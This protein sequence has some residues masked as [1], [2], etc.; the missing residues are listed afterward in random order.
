MTKPTDVAAASLAAEPASTNGTPRSIPLERR[1]PLLIL[2]LLAFVLA[3]S[4][5]VSY[6]EISAS[7]ESSGRDRL[8]S[9][10]QV[11]GSMIQQQ[12]AARLTTMHHAAADSAVVNAL[13]SPTRP[14]SAAATAALSALMTRAD[15]L[16]PARLLTA[17]GDPIGE[18]HLETPADEERF[19]T[20]I[21]S[22]AESVDSSHVGNWYTANGHASFWIAVPVRQNGRVLG[23]V[24]QERRLTNNPRA[25][26]PFRD[27]IGKDIELY[28]RNAS[29]NV[30][31][32]L[33]GASPAP[34]AER[35]SDSI[36]VFA[37]GAKGQVLAATAPVRGTPFL[38]TVEYPMRQL[39][40]RPQATIRTLMVIAVLLTVF[41]A[42][43]AWLI[44]RQLTRPLVELTGAAEAMAE[45]Q[46]A[47]RVRAHGSDEI[48]R[49]GVAFNRMAEQVQVS[50]NASDEAVV[51]LTYSAATQEF[52]AE[53]SRILAESLSDQTLLADLARY[54]VPTLADYSSI[55]VVDDDGSVRRVETAHYDATK[56]D[57][58]RDLVMRYAPRLEEPG[59]VSDVIRSQKPMLLPR[60]DP[61]SIR[62][63]AP[64]ETTAKLIDIIGPTAF[65]CVPLIA[66]GRALGAL[67]FTMTDSGRTFSQDDLDLA[68]ELA[69]RTA[70][71]IDNSV[72]YK[73]SLQLR[74]EAEAASSAKSDFLAKMSHEIRT[75]INAMMG[76][77][78]LLE[79]GISGPVSDAQARQL[80]RIR[81]SGEHLT[82]L[83][84]E[85]LDLAKI[86]AGR[87]AVDPTVGVSG[88]AVDAALGLIRPQAAAK[89]VHLVNKTATGPA[90]EYLGDPQR[91]QQILTNLLSNAVKFTPAGG[92]VIIRA[93]TG[94]R[95]GVADPRAEWTCIVV[96]DT[97]I[98]IG[99]ADLERIFQPFVQV[100]NGY[101]RAHGGTGLGLT[102]SRSLAQMM[103]GG[104][105]VESTVGEG[106]RF[107]LW[108]PSPVA[109][110]L[111]TP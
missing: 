80:S 62:A 108:L 54:C 69:R 15:S 96:Q 47:Q 35:I 8:T 18:M 60:L 52:L 11:I 50:S 63:K 21:R 103:G 78:E 28:F 16:T 53:A 10:S 41:G 14:P 97:G 29:D 39:L 109:V 77:A 37:H 17:N 36:A 13:R 75:P 25:L 6:Y 91:V 30:W 64:D 20:E 32:D 71:A 100:E 33:T 12:V 7:A 92:T 38:I 104:L 68:M 4:L 26:Q 73:R 86:E 1:L 84:N 102:I 74:L 45:G 79:M 90:I 3:I 83:V 82:S 24:A 94:Q 48:G 56:R 34:P 44:S 67:S 111:P 76:Y 95:P 49:L 65:M 88:E 42:L 101:T 81:S 40:A 51:R 46:Y 2:G 99:A 61:A 70:V 22:L 5:F 107:T 89:N 23:Y 106:S 31:V 105:D 27:L 72:I 93:G 57:A 58:V 110:S 43:I 19:R 59:E 9:L 66:R 87:M 98:G 85:I 55:Y